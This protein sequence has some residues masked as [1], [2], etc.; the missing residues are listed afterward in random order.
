METITAA[1]IATALLTKMVEKLGEKVG[2]KL[3]DLG[4]KVWEQV[5]NLKEKLWHN[6]PDT[7]RAIELVT[8]QPELTQQQPQDYAL[9]VLA[10]KIELAAKDPVLA[11]IIEA[12]AAEVR[13]QLTS[14]VVNKSASTTTATAG[15]NSN[16]GAASGFTAQD[17]S[18]VN[19]GSSIKNN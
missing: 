5:G 13:P 1:M 3:P 4:A 8:Y 15:H 2:D 11:Q 17:S 9:E 7:A 6:D 18:T 19:I 12:L 10:G 16:A 14:K